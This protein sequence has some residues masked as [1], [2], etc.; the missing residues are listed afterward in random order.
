[1]SAQEDAASRATHG[2]EALAA[3][4]AFNKEYQTY[5][6][7]R[8][9]NPGL[10]ALSLAKNDLTDDGAR[11]IAQLLR[12]LRG[13][14]ALLQGRDLRAQLAL[15]GLLAGAL[16]LA[17]RRQVERQRGLAGL[18]GTGPLLP[19]TLSWLSRARSVRAPSGSF[20]TM[21]TWRCARLSLGRNWS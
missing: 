12:E 11:E 9:E 19:G 6:A 17:A 7:I 14:E 1:M 20:T 10:R 16:A 5:G 8:Q 2:A 13:G 15:E 18:G 4:L 21:G 3:A